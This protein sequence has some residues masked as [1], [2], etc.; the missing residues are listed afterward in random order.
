MRE[1]INIVNESAV[2]PLAQFLRLLGSTRPSWNG[3]KTEINGVSVAFGIKP[4]AID[5]IEI[6]NIVTPPEMRFQGL[7]SAAMKQIINV[8]DQCGVT[9]ELGI[10]ADDED[11]ALSNDGLRAW[12]EKLGF[13]KSGDVDSLGEPIYV[14]KPDPLNT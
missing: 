1:F 6:D 10:W 3:V 13:L 2:T 4:G 11:D 9:L 14:R 8:A 5:T 12:Y 7:A